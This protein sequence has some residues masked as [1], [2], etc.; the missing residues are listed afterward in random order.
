MPVGG[1]RQGDYVEYDSTC[2]TA[3]FRGVVAAIGYIGAEPKQ[4]RHVAFVDS[5]AGG[6]P[7]LVAVGHLRPGQK[8]QQWAVFR[9]A[10]SE[11]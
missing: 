4:P 10:T 3:I 6:K 8:S 5:C 7:L 11:A 2:S 9:P 1:F